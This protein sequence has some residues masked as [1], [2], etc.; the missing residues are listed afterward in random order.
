MLMSTLYTQKDTNIRKTWILM[1]LFFVLV[2]GVGFVFSEVYQS[3]GVLYVAII[4]SLFMNVLS[5]WYSDKIVLAMSGAHAIEKSDNPEL[6]RT[7]E[8][9]SI[10]AG[11][12]MPRVYLINDSSPNAFATGRNEE[13]AVVAVTTGL[14]ER[15]TKTELE[16]VV[17]H[18]LSH[19][20]NKDILI[21]TVVV[22]LVGFISI[23][24]HIFLR[25]HFFS[26]G[27]NDR[28]NGKAGAILFIVGIVLAI[29]TPIAA[30]LI[31]LAISRRREFLADASGALLTRYPEGLATALIKISEYPVSVKRA[32]EATA[33]IYFASP[34]KGKEAAGWLTKLF[35]THPPT[36]E[37]VAALRNINI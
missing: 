16:G 34:F 14:L 32:Q 23:L 2:I 20:G 33:H 21:S 24:S 12:K 5:Y 3:S 36:P 25:S 7:V 17:A 37:R 26:G 8:N 6:F 4:F 19:I 35:M 22:V 27:R 29:L 11:L 10:T 31:Q 18:E 13:H 1:S 30:T 28:E 15:L 9:L